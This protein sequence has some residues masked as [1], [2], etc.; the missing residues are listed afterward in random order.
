MSAAAAETAVDSIMCWNYV[1]AP[2]ALQK[3]N[4]STEGECWVHGRNLKAS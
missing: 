3:A 2:D 4:G 1:C